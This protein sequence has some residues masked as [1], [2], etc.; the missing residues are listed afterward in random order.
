MIC[1]YPPGR[2]KPLI[3][4][5]YCE[6]TMHGF[7]YQVA[8]HMLRH[9]MEEEGLACVKAVRDR[10]DGYKR[11]PWNEMECGSNYSRSLSSYALLLAYSGF[12]CNMYRKRV[13]FHPIHNDT[14]NFFWSLD[15]G[16]GT[17]EK[18]SGRITW[19]L[20][21]GTLEIR[22]L[23]IELDRVKSVSWKGQDVP[24]AIHDSAIC[25]EEPVKLVRGEYMVVIYE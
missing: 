3:P 20:L 11:N 24:F 6:E 16:F 19:Y 2:K 4:I 25:L 12:V 1:S 18:K 5:P 21:Y 9:H 15:S 8:S 23:E 13:G 14:W 22:E 7:E 10:Y 17:V